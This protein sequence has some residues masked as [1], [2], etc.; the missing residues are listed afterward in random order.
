MALLLPLLLVFIF[1]FLWLRPQQQRMRRQRGLLNEVNVGDRVVTVGGLIGRVID[2]SG[3]RL[4][5]EIADG[6]VVEFLRLAVNRRLDESEAGFVGFGG[7]EEAEEDEE[8]GAEEADGA[9]E[10][11]DTEHAAEPDEGGS[12]TGTAAAGDDATNA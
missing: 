1:Y 5:I 7:G 3:D 8:T 6:V 2:E 10:A 9:D 12:T 11:S 4:Q